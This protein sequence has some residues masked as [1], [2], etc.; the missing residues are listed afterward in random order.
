M[1]FQKLSVT[2]CKQNFMSI[3]QRRIIQ[4]E[5]I[6]LRKKV[7]RSCCPMAYQYTAFVD[8]N[9]FVNIQETIEN[10]ICPVSLTILYDR[11][12]CQR[13]MNKGCQSYLTTSEN[14]E[15]CGAIRNISVGIC[16]DKSSKYVDFDDSGNKINAGP[17]PLRCVADYQDMVDRD[18]LAIEATERKTK[19]H[20]EWIIYFCKIS[21]P[22]LRL[23]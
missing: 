21:A 5:Y 16:S 15:Q 8:S 19:A 17:I 20:G 4:C 7:T 3:D 23:H 12:S 2:Y 6:R 1:L 13:W 14:L 10:N 11:T 18:H 9:K 22:R